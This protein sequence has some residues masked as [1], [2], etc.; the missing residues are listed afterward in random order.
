MSSMLRKWFFLI[1]LIAFAHSSMAAEPKTKPALIKVA[2]QVKGPAGID[3]KGVSIDLY[4]MD[5]PL[6]GLQKTF[7]PDS[8]GSLSLTFI[9]ADW[10]ETGDASET[11]AS[12]GLYHIVVTAS[13]TA[14]AVSPILYLASENPS[15]DDASNE[16]GPSYSK[17]LDLRELEKKN[18]PL[19]LTLEQGGTLKGQVLTSDGKPFPGVKIG[20]FH[21]LH[22]DSHTGKGR[23]VL[24]QETGTD[25]QGVFT[26][27]GVFPNTVYI[28]EIVQPEGEK[29]QGRFWKATR[30]N[31]RTFDYQENTLPLASRAAGLELVLV[32]SQDR[33]RYSG[34]VR[35]SDGK[36]IAGAGMNMSV[37]Y[38]PDARDF[39]DSHTFVDGKTDVQGAFQLE[40]DAPFVNFLNIS[41]EGFKEFSLDN[42]TANPPYSLLKPGTH[43]FTLEKE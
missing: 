18:Q 9:D 20:I 42:E 24:S 29:G 21:D 4:G 38:H 34:V 22:A 32:V 33:Y 26:F 25:Q 15:F 6:L 19:V 3:M 14:G 13:G 10:D 11:P 1:A 27:A 31:G 41:K 8:K 35:G 43:T 36:P 12:R 17:P 5:R 30:I 16:W 23:E 28:G 2:V 40:T 7:R 39:I 37:A